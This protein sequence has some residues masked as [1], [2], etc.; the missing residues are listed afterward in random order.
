MVD[1]QYFLATTESEQLLDLVLTTSAHDP[2]ILIFHGST[3]LYTSIQSRP[4]NA[5]LHD[6]PKQT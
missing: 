3:K 2:E 1:D 5:P 4:R 6:Q